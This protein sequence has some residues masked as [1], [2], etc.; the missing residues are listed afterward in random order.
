[1]SKTNSE[2][3]IKALKKQVADLKDAAA[4][5][6][7]V[8]DALRASEEL[9]RA[10]LESCPVP[11]WRLDENEK[12]LMANEALARLLGYESR[13]E[14]QQLV[15]ILGLFTSPDQFGCVRQ[16]SM[17]QPNLEIVVALRRKDGT[18]CQALTRITRAESPPSFIFVVWEPSR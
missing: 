8:E 5:R 16:S 17:G 1:M 9:A 7:R 18:V 12:L 6:R 14:V 2:I 4:V 10:T 13:Y 11:L 15:P 3:E